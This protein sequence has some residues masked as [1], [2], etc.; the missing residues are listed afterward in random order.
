MLFRSEWD[1]GG[2]HYIS[3]EPY[4]FDGA[5]GKALGPG[6]GFI[7]YLPN[8]TGHAPGTDLYGA[9]DFWT[10]WPNRHIFYSA[11][12]ILGRWGLHNLEMDYGFFS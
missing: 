5:D 6:A 11:A 9:Y 8:A 1:E 12:D 10:W 7:F 4:G 2:I 3:S